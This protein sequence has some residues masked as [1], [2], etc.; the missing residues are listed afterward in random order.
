[1]A[2]VDSEH[3]AYFSTG[4]LPI[5]AEG[6]N[7]Q[8]PTLGN[9]EY[10]WKGFLSREQHPHEVDP[11]SGYLTN[12]NN[13]P[14]PGWGQAS[15]NWSWG[16]I[17]RVQLFKGFGSGMTEASDVSIMNKAATQDLRSVEIWPTIEA[18]LDTPGSKVPSA[19]TKE[20]VKK[21]KAWVKSG[22]SR[23]GKEGPKAPA[24]AIMDA[25]WTPIGEAVLSPVLGELLPDFASL[26]GANN[27]ENSQG[28]S[29][30]GGW[31]GYVYKSLRE[32]L[33][34]TVAQPFSRGYCGSGNLEACR[35]SLWTAIEGAV[36]NLESQQGTSEIKAWRA[37]K[38]RIDFLPG[39][40]SETMTWTNRSTFQQV[41]EFTGHAAE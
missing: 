2:Y 33:G 41:I 38:V 4:R 40:D 31:Y 20:A 7:P 5:T 26:D 1:M 13:K 16:P 34:D 28:S 22:S 10:E 17:H 35:N 8:L 19:L 32:E 27:G 23:Y 39:I 29:Y 3:I 24:A 25:I 15:D 11:V 36:N 6:T 14:A 37:E 21:L 12:W 18:V 30:G 9:G